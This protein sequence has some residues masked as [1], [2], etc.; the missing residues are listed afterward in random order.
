MHSLPDNRPV[1][2]PI[3]QGQYPVRVQGCG[4]LEIENEG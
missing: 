2:E 4:L 3:S 1:I